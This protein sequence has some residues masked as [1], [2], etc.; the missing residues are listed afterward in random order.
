MPSRELALLAHIDER[1]AVMPVEALLHVGDGAFPD[2]GLGVLHEFEESG[3][4][5][6]HGRT[7]EIAA[8]SRQDILERG[9]REAAMG[10]DSSKPNNR[11]D[12]PGATVPPMSPEE[13]AILKHRLATI[14]DA[15]TGEELLKL[16]KEEIKRRASRR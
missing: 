3:S 14:D 8:A 12:A 15:V 9:K 6:G 5:L 16:V 7:L 13:L 10:N 2:A 4:V 1:E 11:D